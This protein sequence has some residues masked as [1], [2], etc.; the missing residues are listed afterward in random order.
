VSVFSQK[1]KQL[2]KKMSE[3]VSDSNVWI[4]VTSVFVG[5]ISLIIVVLAFIIIGDLVQKYKIDNDCL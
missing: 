1:K 5:L 4:I 2:K 3:F